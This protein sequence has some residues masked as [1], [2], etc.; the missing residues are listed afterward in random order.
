MK[1]ELKKRVSIMCINICRF[2]KSEW[3]K[4]WRNIILYFIIGIVVG[5]LFRWIR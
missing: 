5:L 1:Q 2:Y 4:H 3:G